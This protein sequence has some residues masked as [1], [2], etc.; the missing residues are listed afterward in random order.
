MYARGIGGLR[1]I[2]TAQGTTS[3]RIHTIGPQPILQHFLERMGFFRIVRSCLGTPREGLL[4]HAQTLSTFAR[5]ILLSPAPLYRIAEWAAP[6][7]AEALGLSATQKESLND[8][9]VA[10]TLDALATPRALNLDIRLA[11]HIIKQFEIDTRQIHHDTTTVT[12]Y[13]QYKTSIKEPQITNGYNKDHRPDLKQ[14][15][16]GLNVTADGAVP[17]S[18]NIY[19]GNRTDDSIHP[20]NIDRLREI[21]GHEDFI[22]VADCKLCTRKNLQ[23][24]TQYGGR[25]V[26]VMPRS[27]AEDKQFRAKL[28]DGSRVRWRKLTKLENKRHATDDAADIYSTTS[29]G[30]NETKDGYRLV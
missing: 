20:G 8:D 25:F 9:R 3:L 4:D 21:L 12:F 24:V 30:P 27:W 26:T 18:H 6:I 1:Q 10:R 23:Y 15:V 7:D 22:Y 5:N 11:L 14:L 16:F 28:R 29:A 19:S 17:I 2:K 13:G